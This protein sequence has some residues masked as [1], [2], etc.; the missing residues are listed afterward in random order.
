MVKTEDPMPGTDQ[1]KPHSSDADRVRELIGQLAAGQAQ[2]EEARKLAKDLRD[3]RRFD[4]LDSL[5]EQARR[6]LGNDP[7]LA[8]LQAQSLID[9]GRAVNALDV[10]RSLLADLPPND[11]EAIEARGLMGRAWK[12]IFFDMPDKSLKIARKALHT[13]LEQYTA[14]FEIDFDNPWLAVNVLALAVYAQRNNI[15]APSAI[16]P[17]DLARKIRTT[18]ETVP[19]DKRDN[20][21]H[22][23]QAEAFLGLDDVDSAEM[24]IGAYVQS[25]DTTAF[26]LAGTLRQFTD[27]W[28]LDR[29]GK[30]EQGIVEALRAALLRKKDG[31]L[32]LS[33]NEVAQSGDARHAS[34]HQLQKILGAD[35]VRTYDWL[36]MGMKAARA[37]GA[38][39]TLAG[40]RQGT[41][42]LVRGK[43][44]NPAF[45]NDLVVVTN[46]HV[47]CSPPHGCAVRHERA[48]IVFEAAQR[49]VRYKFS[50]ILWESPADRLDC[51]ILRLETQPRGI[52]PLTIAGK[53][54]PLPKDPKDPRPRVYVIG[55]P[56]GRSLAF[57]L[58]DN[59]LLDH[60]APPDGKP[61]YENVCRVQY[62]APTEPGS[63]G[64][65]VFDAYEW[66]VIA[67]H[68]AGDTSM[69]RLNQMDGTWAANEGL[70]M[71]SIIA[72]VAKTQAETPATA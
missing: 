2:V 46:A 15:P 69:Y 52:Q 3:K 54:D 23:S 33:V 64:S 4:L 71:Q 19:K 31:Q 41:G 51:T 27:L 12:Q 49:G 44:L 8:R 21:Y 47:I 34:D 57:S 24:H 22:A 37:V 25:E 17:P 7:P 10:L 14:A 11:P 16:Q 50:G 39:S 68:H 72:A 55:Y 66:Q 1:D 9:L 26:A 13:S 63:S 45:G 53:I 43:D 67:L 48:Q 61:P 59:E 56:G 18:L 6:H 70:W 5:A 40:D 65:P 29:N 30:R 20:W 62:R 58:Q 42:W 36:Q 38:I 60:E 28:Q 35:G 32:E